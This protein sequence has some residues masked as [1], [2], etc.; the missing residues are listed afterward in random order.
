MS[1]SISRGKSG[2]T[3]SV[4]AF[5]FGGLAPSLGTTGCMLTVA[6]GTLDGASTGVAFGCQDPCCNFKVSIGSSKQKAKGS[7]R[8]PR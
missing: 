6:V 3:P 5:V 1:A 8:G 7:R 2:G 4:H